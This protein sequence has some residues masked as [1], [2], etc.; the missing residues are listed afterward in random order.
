V[1]PILDWCCEVAPIGWIAGVLG[2][3][4]TVVTPHGREVTH[5][6]HVVARVIGACVVVFA[7]DVF[8]DVL[9]ALAGYA[10]AGKAIEGAVR[11]ILHRTTRTLRSAPPTIATAKLDGAFVAVVWAHD[12][13]TRPGLEEWAEAS[14]QRHHAQRADTYKSKYVPHKLPPRFSKHR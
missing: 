7:Y 6:V 1:C 12:A 2:A 5:P 11:S 3:P 14:P 13:R 10:D 4:I 8:A 9:S